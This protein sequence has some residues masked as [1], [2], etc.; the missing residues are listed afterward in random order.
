MLQCKKRNKN[1]GGNTVHNET[2]TDTG[3]HYNY[4]PNY[5]KTI[6]IVKGLWMVHWCSIFIGTELPGII[7]K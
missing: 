6:K 3:A 4:S 2:N 7:V 1:D 5:F